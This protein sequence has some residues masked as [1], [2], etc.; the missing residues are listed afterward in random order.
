MWTNMTPSHGGYV[1]RTSADSRV[2][3]P[4]GVDG[5]YQVI[6]DHLVAESRTAPTFMSFVLFFKQNSATY[7]KDN[8][9][10]SGKLV[11]E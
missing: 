8:Y 9:K 10:E 3:W 6:Q 7:K 4:N 1:S 5:Q 2:M 11:I